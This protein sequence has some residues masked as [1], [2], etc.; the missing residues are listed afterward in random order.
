MAFNIARAFA[1][2]AD[3]FGA[4]PRETCYQRNRARG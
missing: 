2:S 1:L 3:P 4:A